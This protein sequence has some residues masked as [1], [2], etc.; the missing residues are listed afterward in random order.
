MR[1]R[2]NNFEPTDEQLF[3]MM[4]ADDEVEIMT[5]GDAP[6][7][8][9][10]LETLW[11]K[12]PTKTRVIAKTRNGEDIMGTY[13]QVPDLLNR[14][15]EVFGLNYN[16]HFEDDIVEHKDDAF[17]IV[18]CRLTVR[19]D[20]DAQVLMDYGTAPLF[21][22]NQLNP[23][24]F[25]AAATDAFKRTVRWLGIGMFQYWGDEPPI[26]SNATEPSNA[27]KNATK[28]KTKPKPDQKEVNPDEALVKAKRVRNSLVE[29]GVIS[30]ELT[31]EEAVQY[32]TEEFNLTERQAYFIFATKDRAERFLEMDETVKP[33]DFISQEMEALKAKA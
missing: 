22:G 8:K 21:R 29:L 26:M 27:T 6:T 9:T 7:P 32:A 1:K 33:S 4:T 17:V 3:E 5:A 18:R 23:D 28:T 31:P 15:Q 10:V 25:K 16:I 30:D 11:E 12:L 2:K 19:R 14:L 20:G 13:I 24:A